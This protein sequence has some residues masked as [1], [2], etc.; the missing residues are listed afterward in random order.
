MEQTASYKT[1]SIAEF[2]VK[3]SNDI[4]TLPAAGSAL[5]LSGAIAASLAIFVTKL[6]NKNV[7]SI[8]NPKL[9]QKNT[10]HMMTL[11][12]S[13]MEIM[14]LDKNAYEKIIQNIGKTYINESDKTKGNQSLLKAYESATQIQMKLNDISLSLLDTLDAIFENV[15][16][17]SQADAFIAVELAYA[18][19]KGSS[20]I[21]HVNVK[22]I[23]N[24][25]LV[26]SFIQRIQDNCDDGKRIYE[27]IVNVNPGIKGAN[28]GK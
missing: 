12:Q 11:Q 9:R 8:D 15:P 1:T 28:N 20:Y 21:V 14:D 18:C 16:K 17:V 26:K 19:L 4:P 24:Q 13:C 10:D 7:L 25:A 22:N 27:K 3:L 5:G 2:L 23:Q 6:V